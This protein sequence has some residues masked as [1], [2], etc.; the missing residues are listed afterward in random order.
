MVLIYVY[1]RFYVLFWFLLFAAKLINYNYKRVC[2]FSI[3][4]RTALKTTL[5]HTIVRKAYIRGGGKQLFVFQPFLFV[6]TI[7]GSSHIFGKETDTPFRFFLPNLQ[8]KPIVAN[9]Y[10]LKMKIHLFNNKAFTPLP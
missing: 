5:L 7:K 1:T 8:R 3:F 4:V 10:K 6:F 2:F 9:P